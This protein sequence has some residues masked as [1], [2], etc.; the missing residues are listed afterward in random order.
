MWGQSSR[1][2][3]TEAQTRHLRSL[4]CPAGVKVPM[5]GLAGPD[6]VQGPVVAVVVVRLGLFGGCVAGDAR[7][8]LDVPTLE[9][10]RDVGA[11]DVLLALEG[12][13]VGIAPAMAAGV[14]GG[15]LLAVT[16]SAI[17]LSSD[18]ESQAREWFPRIASE[19]KA[20]WATDRRMSGFYVRAEYE[21]LPDVDGEYV[22]ETVTWQRWVEEAEAGRILTRAENGDV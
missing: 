12:R 7:S 2:S 19:S 1:W 20:M 11:G 15:A 8:L 10:H 21:W 22:R 16:P 6:D 18:E 9:V 3:V 13:E 4:H 14:L 17:P 5:A